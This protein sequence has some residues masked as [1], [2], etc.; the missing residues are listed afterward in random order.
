MA[1]ERVK[2]GG[3]AA[4]SSSAWGPAVAVSTPWAAAGGGAV[5]RGALNVA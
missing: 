1:K 3:S 4:A 5:P 2:V